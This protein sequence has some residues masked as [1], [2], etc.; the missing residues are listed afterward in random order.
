[1]NYEII[2]T[3][4]NASQQA[5]MNQFLYRKYEVTELAYVSILVFVRG[6]GT[7]KGIKLLDEEL[8]SLAC[9]SRDK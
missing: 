6:F 5:I 1:M 9:A 4:T 8:K 7:L 3:L 2:R